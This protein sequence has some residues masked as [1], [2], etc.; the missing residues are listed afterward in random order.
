[1]SNKFLTIIFFSINISISFTFANA[2]I[3]IPL[4]SKCCDWHYDSEYGEPH[5]VIT[6]DSGSVRFKI[7][8]I[9]SRAMINIKASALKIYNKYLESNP[10]LEGTIVVQ[11]T[12]THD[13]NVINDTIL[14]S[15]TKNKKF[16]EDIINSICNYKW[17]KIDKGTTTVT[18]PLTFWKSKEDFHKSKYLDENNLQKTCKKKTL[19]VI[20]NMEYSSGSRSKREIMFV[21]N[22]RKP[23]LRNTYNRY[24]AQ[25]DFNGKVTFKFT[26]APN[27]N[28]TNIFIVSST[29]GYPEFDNDIKELISTWKWK[30][31]KED[32]NH[33]VTIT[34][35]FQA[36][37]PKI[38]FVNKVVRMISYRI[39]F[40]LF[41]WLW[42]VYRKC[43]P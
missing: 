22:A 34:L 13:G 12:V 9:R 2:E 14:S 40:Y 4:N 39:V 7:E 38:Q 17:E 30:S 6:L 29:T 5:D 11:F 42:C 33:I 43:N 24:L 32:V 28:V 20:V 25:N 41:L 3:I 19:K 15:T 36:S 1:V 18:V 35:N 23:G 31:I 10:Y 16:D 21:F 37:L 27:G 26:I 8:F